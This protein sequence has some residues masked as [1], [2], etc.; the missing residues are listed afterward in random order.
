MADLLGQALLECYRA[1]LAAY[2]PQGW[3]PGEGAFEVM[4]GAV[5]TQ[6]TAWRNVER[7]L[8]NLQAAGVLSPAGLRDLPRGELERL[9]RPAGTY[10]V[11][12][13]RLRALLEYLWQAHGGDP[14]GLA[15]GDLMTLRQ[16]LLAVPGIGPE[17]ADSI[18]LYAGGHP[19][20]VVDA[21]T[22]RLLARLGLF[23]AG[24]SYEQVQTLFMQ[25][26]P[27]DAALFNE[28]HALIV[29]HSKERCRGHSPRCAGCPL[30][31]GCA[32]SNWRSTVASP[33]SS[34]GR[35]SW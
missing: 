16:E 22:R 20:F 23:P 34:G 19:I 4:V 7:A 12:A 30:A 8:S 2:G 27:A 24:G 11:K 18:L 13:G 28:Y 14:A 10:R 35:A 15:R 3:W 9:L 32:R 33:G 6:N 5:L 21:Y 25:H 17:T 31:M 26:L 1:L 29:R